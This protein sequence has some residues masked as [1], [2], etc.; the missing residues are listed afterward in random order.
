MI[1]AKVGRPAKA[2]EQYAKEHFG[3]KFEINWNSE[4]V[5]P[6]FHA[7]KH[8]SVGLASARIERNINLHGN[9]LRPRTLTPL[10][11]IIKPIKG[12]EQSPTRGLLSSSTKPPESPSPPHT[13]VLENPPISELYHSCTILCSHIRRRNAVIQPDST[14]NIVLRR[15]LDTRR[16]LFDEQELID[17][18]LSRVLRQRRILCNALEAQLCSI[19]KILWKG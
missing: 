2:C 19:I 16:L 3:G 7:T 17:G 1:G 8:S 15:Q 13:H 4:S 6:N 14:N 10:T 9:I 11:S 12:R 18:P 5:D